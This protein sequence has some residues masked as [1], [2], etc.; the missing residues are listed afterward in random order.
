[1]RLPT[2]L[3][4]ATLSI[5]VWVSFA[6]G[7]DVTKPTPAVI[8]E[9]DAAAKVDEKPPEVWIHLVGG[10]RI[11][12]DEV[13]EGT[14]GIWYTRNN[15][16]TFLDPARVVRIERTESSKKP[17]AS[18]GMTRKWTLSDSARVAAFFE[19][20][21]KRPLP[22]SALGQSDLH[23][24]WGWDH[25]NGMDV[26]LHPDSDEGKALIDFLTREQIPF[27][28]FRSFIPGVAT[29]PHIHVGHGSS[30]LRSR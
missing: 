2:V 30:K 7:Q 20:R 6:S 5:L 24:R 25:R 4:N 27:L 9:T 17:N 13:T 18:S 16:S 26:G 15:I 29:G 8:S 21:F 10:R 3:L 14:D 28:A 19:S 22:L 1:M 12:V 23:D 11:Q